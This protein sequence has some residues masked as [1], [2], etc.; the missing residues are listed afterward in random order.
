MT[1]KPAES[2][3]SLESG[4]PVVLETVEALRKA[5]RGWRT[6]GETV[7]LVPT[8][9]A[10]HQGHLALIEAAFEAADRVVV[11]IFVNPAQFAPEEDFDA[12]PRA[13]EADLKH[14]AEARVDTAFVPSAAEMYPPDFATTVRVGAVTEGL[15]GATRPHFFAG[16]ATVVTKL[17][18]QCLPEAAIFGEKDYQQ[19][20]AVRRLVRDLDIPTRI[21]AVA[22]VR[23][24]DGLAVSSRNAYLTPEQRRIARSL[25]AVLHAMA[26]R[27]AEGAPAIQQV[28]RGMAELGVAGF[29]GVEYLAVCDADSLEPISSVERPARVLAAVYLGTTRLIDNVPVAPAARA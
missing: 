2:A 12:Y 26:E 17:L 7:A 23:E 28:D 29:D 19:L 25:S 21:I 27:L 4:P 13:G 18:L 16:V 1:A 22:T 10:L 5:V 8:M 15:C 6:R 14:L 9:G 11:S 20:V 3:D 24:P